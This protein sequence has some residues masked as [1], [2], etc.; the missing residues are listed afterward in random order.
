MAFGSNTSRRNLRRVSTMRRCSSVSRKSTVRSWRFVVQSGSARSEKGARLGLAP[1]DL[2]DGPGSRED[3]LGAL[4]DRNVHH[5]SV[6]VH[7]RCSAPKAVLERL[8]DT[9][10]VL[11][12]RRIG[13][14]DPIEYLDLLGVNAS[15]ALAAELA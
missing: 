10:R 11:D 3:D 4:V 1:L 15:R 9:S 6:E 7:R 2:V 12:L 5:L 14:E 13:R 8:G